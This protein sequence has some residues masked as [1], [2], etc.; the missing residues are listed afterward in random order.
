MA[1]SAKAVRIGVIAEE[2]NDIDVIY[3][4]TCKIIKENQFSF[5]HFIGHGCGKVRKK[6]NAWDKTY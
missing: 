3:E 4:L 1:G 6:C 2:K 5:S